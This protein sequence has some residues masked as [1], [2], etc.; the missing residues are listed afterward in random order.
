ML[1]T[2]AMQLH[3]NICFHVQYVSSYVCII[4]TVKQDF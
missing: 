4:E 1:L 2:D 3:K